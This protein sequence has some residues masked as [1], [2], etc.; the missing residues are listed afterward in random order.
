MP[1][2]KNIENLADNEYG[3]GRISHEYADVKLK[4]LNELRFKSMSFDEIKELM[5]GH[6]HYTDGNKRKEKIHDRTVIR[7]IQSIQ[8]SFQGD[9]FNG[10]F[11]VDASKPWKA[12]TYK[13]N[14]YNFP[15]TTTQDELDALK[16]VIDDIPKTNKTL[17][18]NLQK[19]HTKLFSTWTLYHQKAKDMSYKEMDDAQ[20]K[21]DNLT[22]VTM[23]PQFQTS[24]IAEIYPALSYAIL[25]QLKILATVK[26][27]ENLKKHEDRIICPLGFLYGPNN[28]YLALYETDKKYDDDKKCYIDE[29]SPNFRTYKLSKFVEVKLMDER[30]SSFSPG[31]FDLKKYAY[32]IFGIPHNREATKFYDI[33]W[34]VKDKKI[35]QDVKQYK[36]HSPQKLI[37]N[38]DGTL[39]IKFH[40]NNLP[41]IAKYLTQWGGD[42]I[43]IAPEE[44]KT[45]YRNLLK[46]CLKSISEE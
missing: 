13:L 3:Y 9:E 17:H 36:F 43:P 1:K 2:R 32:S 22:A 7:M 14:L 46:D 16:L 35:M 45:E 21:L 42:I 40:T 26:T 39:T 31:K 38:D 41:A 4:I 33:E 30:T 44:L 27:G 20:Y 10:E 8:H 11:N 5:E 15:D 18:D 29:N 23:G 37:S 28:V 6:S 34:L 19:L 24:W 25:K 12:Q